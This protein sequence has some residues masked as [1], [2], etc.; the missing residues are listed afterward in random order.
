MEERI[1]RRARS[2]ANR[3][4]WAASS[5]N[6]NNMRKELIEVAAPEIASE[7][8]GNDGVGSG[9]LAELRRIMGD[10]NAALYKRIASAEI[11]LAYELAPGAAVGVDPDSIAAGSFKFLKA[12]IDARGTPEA[13]R[14]K[15]L[16]LLASVENTRAAARSDAVTNEAKG[17]LLVALC[18]SE[19]IRA[20]RAANRWND[21]VS[22]NKPWAIESGDEIEAPRDWFG[23]G[24]SWPAPDK[25]SQCLEQAS[26]ERIAAFKQELLSIRTTNR[27]DRFDELMADTPSATEPQKD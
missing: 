13:L 4:A 9:S 12:C 5:L 26:P 23:V 24:W 3:A 19:R 8:G 6:A 2:A 17:R 11:V 16:K 25:L 27:I 21:V 22:K 1:S 15:A 18:N 10:P 14:F 20:L 7:P